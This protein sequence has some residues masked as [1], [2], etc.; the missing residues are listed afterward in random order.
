M[1]ISCGAWHC[2]R[3]QEVDMFGEISGICFSPEADKFFVGIADA[4]YS[5][6]LQFDRHQ[7]EQYGW[8]GW[9]MQ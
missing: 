9:S 4:T 6:L 8:S 1:L 3:S 5:S 2:C 7:P